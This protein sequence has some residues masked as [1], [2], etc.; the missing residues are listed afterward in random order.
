[1][2]RGVQKE[3]FQTSSVRVSL[4]PKIYSPAS[5]LASFARSAFF[6]IFVFSS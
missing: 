4:I 5:F 6:L 1:M 3:Q 2:T